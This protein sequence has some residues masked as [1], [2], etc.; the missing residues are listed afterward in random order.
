MKPTTRFH[1]P[2]HWTT[3]VNQGKQR[4]FS[5]DTWEDRKGDLLGDPE[6]RLLGNRNRAKAQTP[7]QYQPTGAGE[8]TSRYSSLDRF[9]RAP[10]NHYTRFLKGNE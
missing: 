3:S 6:N 8:V 1:S 7:S 9:H 10:R 4:I 2:F 5:D